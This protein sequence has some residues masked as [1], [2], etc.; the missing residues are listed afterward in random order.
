M[1]PTFTAAAL[2]ALRKALPTAMAVGLLR[3]CV[4]HTAKLL[5]TETHWRGERAFADNATPAWVANPKEGLERIEQIRRLMV[6]ERP[7]FAV[8]ALEV[9]RALVIHSMAS[10]LATVEETPDDEVSRGAAAIAT[11]LREM[12]RTFGLGAFVVLESHPTVAATA[13]DM[14]GW[15]QRPT[16]SREAVCW[17]DI[18]Y[19][20]ACHGSVLRD[21]FCRDR[22]GWA[23]VQW[24]R[25]DVPTGW[26]EDIHAVV[27]RL[28]TEDVAVS[29]LVRVVRRLR[30]TRTA[31]DPEAW[32]RAVG[33]V[34]NVLDRAP[35]QHLEVTALLDAA[36]CP[37]TG[38]GD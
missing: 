32:G 10:A 7:A 12:A 4:R 25:K 33:A 18:A 3:Y 29:D 5:G 15:P 35:R 2:D 22:G 6:E 28:A 20:A 24:L 14:P 1:G 37:P 23:D 31:M 26:A 17:D 30:A 27:T 9:Q 8:S 19:R 16:L 11:D 13:R 36:F 21:R 34:R 38:W